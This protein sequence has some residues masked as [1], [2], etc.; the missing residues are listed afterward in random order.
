MDRELAPQ[1]GIELQEPT[2]ISLKAA[3]LLLR[4]M[5]KSP[6]PPSIESLALMLDSVLNYEWAV[7]IIKITSELQD[8]SGTIEGMEDNLRQFN[9]WTNDN[10]R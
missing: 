9:E 10:L 1:S 7:R 3:Y 2:G 6:E 8:Q 4:E 5:N